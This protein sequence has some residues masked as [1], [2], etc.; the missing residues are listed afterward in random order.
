MGI[1]QSDLEH[2]R[3]MFAGRSRQGVR[4]LCV[5]A[6]QQ[7]LDASPGETLVSMHGTLGFWIER[8]LAKA[9]GRAE[10]QSAK[11]VFYADGQRQAVM[12]PAMDFVWWMIRA[13]LATPDFLIVTPLTHAGARPE[14]ARDPGTYVNQLRLTDLGVRFL[15]TTPDHPLAPGYL[16][17]LATRLPDFPNGTLALLRDAA[18]CLEVALYR[19]ALVVL[20]VAAETL[21]EDA[22]GELAK[23]GFP[24]ASAALKKQA[25]DR[26][27]SFRK[28]LPKLDLGKEAERMTD[29]ALSY[30]DDLRTRRNQASHTSLPFEDADELE[31]LAVASS[32]HLPKL[33]DAAKAKPGAAP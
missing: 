12:A 26:I 30:A 18:A 20:G 2:V 3:R 27:A 5:Q 7:W 19:P 4:A 29:A 10:I 14:E 21:I 23:H 16:E 33:W 1:P 6:L 11:E 24:E 22:L 13:G 8:I 32:Y 9:E 28:L 17:R 15:Q 25:G 31:Q